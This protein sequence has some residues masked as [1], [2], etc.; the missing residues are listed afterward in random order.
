MQLTRLTD[1]YLVELAKPPALGRTVTV[2]LELSDDEVELSSL[3]SRYNPLTKTIT[4]TA[5]DLDW[6]RPVRMVVTARQDFRREDVGA[7]V[8]THRLDLSPATADPAYLFASQSVAVDVYDDD[9]PGVLVYETGGS[10]LVIL[11]DTTS[12]PGAT[13]TYTI[14]L[15]KAPNGTVTIAL[16]TDGKTDVASL[17]GAPVTLSAVGGLIPL[18]PVHGR[19]RAQRRDDHARPRLRARQLPD[20]GLRGRPDAQDRGRRGERRRLHDPLSDGRR[21]HAGDAAR[22]WQLRSREPEPR[23]RAAASSAATSRSTRSRTGSRA[24]AAASSRTAS[25]RGC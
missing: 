19:G 6:N 4:F 1:E 20:R 12:G 10:T 9:T 5:A 2:K 22:R 17:D 23:R 3:D 15:T 7:T 14:R 11:G 8:I 18:A 21:D 13:D 16:L 25:S 24:R